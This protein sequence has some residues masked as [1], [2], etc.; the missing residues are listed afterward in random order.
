M[1]GIANP[2]KAIRI[3]SLDAKDLYN[4]NHLVRDN[5]IG[6]SIR[7]KN[8]ELNRRKF[9]NT[10]D[11]SLEQ[12]KLREVYERVCRR[13]NFS[14]NIDGFDYTQHVINVTFKYAN[15]EFNRYYGNLYVRQGYLPEDVEI[16]DCVC[17]RDGEILAVLTGEAVAQP[18][19]LGDQFVYKDGKYAV[20]KIKQTH[21]RGE[22]R[23]ILYRDGF[24]CDGIHYVRFKRSAGSAR[25]GKCLFINEAL[26]ARMHKWELCGLSV[27]P[28]DKLDTAA[29]ESYISLTCSSIIDTVEIQPENI[30][31]IDDYNSL[32]KEKCVAVTFDDKQKRLQSAIKEVDICNSIWDGQSLLDTSLFAGCEKQGM[33]LLRN[34]FFK[35]CCFNTNLQA[36]FADNGITEVSQ[37]AGRTRAKSIADVK[38]VTTPSSIKYL[39]FGTFDQWLDNLE[40]TFG[41]VKHEKRTHFF[42]GRMVQCH[43]Q[44]LNS[45]QLTYDETKK[46][47][48]P[49]MEYL[50]LIKDDPCVFRYSIKHTVV[51]DD[52]APVE[53]LNFK[54]DII[55]KMLG[56]NDRFAETKLYYGF[57]K[58]ATNAMSNSIKHG[59]L[60]VNGNYST[61][62]GNPIEMLKASIGAFDGTSGIDIGTIH[63]RRF[64]PH[65][66][67]LGCRSPHVCSGNVWVAKN[68]PVAAIDHYFNLSREIVCVNSIGENLLERL[69]GA[70][71]DSDTVMLTDNPVLLAAAKRNY[72]NFPVPTKL[73]DAKKITRLYTPESLCDMDI[74]TS[75]NK[76][77]EIINL[78]QEL[79]TLMW[80]SIN[81]GASIDSIMPLYCDI[82]QLDVM[83]NIE[84][85]SAKKEYPVDNT[86]E[87][88]ELKA[89]YLR[90]DKGGKRIMPNFFA[91]VSRRKG[92]YNPSKKTYL[93]HHSTMD[94]LQKAMREFARK[95]S[96]YAHDY[97]P[98]AE[99]LNREYMN[100]ANSNFDQIDR[101][102]NAVRAANEEIKSIWV[103]TENYDNTQKY[104]IANEIRQRCVEHV[105]SIRFNGTTMYSLLLLIEDERYKDVSRMLF[106]ILFGAP[107]L[108]FF[109]ILDSSRQPRDVLVEGKSGDIRIYD[110][111]FAKQRIPQR[112]ED[113]VQFSPN[114]P[115]ISAQITRFRRGFYP[116]D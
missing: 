41:L 73:V 47:V 33:M 86:K 11:A 75:V 24:F 44:L 65:M 92:Y 26:Y 99:I 3:L 74:A 79:N 43:Y 25:V 59:H 12:I 66:D 83:S 10:L 13:I 30:L 62:F 67:I 36:F 89:K 68:I 15:R 27:K 60:L 16:D 39:K 17:E 115:S 105:G 18:R 77:G 19:G 64:R 111:T 71:F 9:I 38:L 87:L 108:S 78:S 52:N 22:L 81:K 82:A 93:S 107:N 106:S 100:V 112:I 69:S 4:T 63:S 90:T 91:P 31:L 32:F 28:G 50:N 2:L 21:S 88:A 98:F 29:F 20:G 48:R 103:D 49:S 51:D 110:F 54:N 76:I 7:L 35:S 58:D 72:N 70:D 53:G 57:L 1:I 96:V 45:L 113:F 114:P 56:V 37:L 85:D 109:D 84:I 8:G 95:R 116:C 104:A 94:Y 80:D 42:N 55:Y 101:V 5:P 102:I 14:V 23:K 61:L 34:R 40:S 97:L 6:Y 46:L